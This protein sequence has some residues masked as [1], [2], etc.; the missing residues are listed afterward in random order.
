M[1]VAYA[2]TL[3]FSGIFT[4]WFLASAAPKILGVDLAKVSKEL[5]AKMGTH[6][7]VGEQ[8]YQPI[9]ARAYRLANAALVGHT[10]RELAPL[11]KARSLRASG[12]GPRS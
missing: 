10:P 4:A 5:E 2:V 3:P 11:C 9:V 12:K 8:A 1:G 7:T 6:G